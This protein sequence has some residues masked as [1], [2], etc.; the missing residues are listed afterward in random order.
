MLW[1]DVFISDNVKLIIFHRLA[2]IYKFNFERKHF[3][4][5]L[6]NINGPSFRVLRGDFPGESQFGSIVCVEKSK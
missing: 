3:V 5:S 4:E 1:L 6:F 2:L